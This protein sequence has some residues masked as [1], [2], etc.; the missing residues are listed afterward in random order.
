MKSRSLNNES[1]LIRLTA[2]G[3]ENA[4]RQIFDFYSNRLH[5]YIYRI[6]ESEE[7]AEDIVM[8]AFIKIWVNRS[9]LQSITNFDSYLYAMVRNQAFNAIKRIAHESRIIRELSLNSTEYQYSTE[10]TVVYNDYKNLVKDAMDQ[11]PPQQRLVY[12]LSRDEGLKY[13]EIA[14][15]LNLS[16][17]TVKAHLKKALSSMRTVLS[18]YMAVSIFLSFFLITP[19]AGT[20]RLINAKSTALSLSK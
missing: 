19:P 7:I 13:D 10:E 9:K 17:N 2:L 3:D 11:L 8:D 4:F 20:L 14:V 6:T 15:E 18:G 1:D 16:K 5:N 12:T